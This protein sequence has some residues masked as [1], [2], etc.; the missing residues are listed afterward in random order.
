MLYLDKTASIQRL[1]TQAGNVNK[2][3]FTAVSG[4]EAIDVNVQPSNPETVALVN[5]I[6]GKTYDVFTTASGIKEGDKLTVSG[7]FVDN[8]TQNKALR[9]SSVANWYFG[10]LPHFELV[11]TD[12]K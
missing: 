6:Y 11:C 7:T 1:T 12:L 10:P 5:G 3:E 8:L 9:V 4:M 2:G